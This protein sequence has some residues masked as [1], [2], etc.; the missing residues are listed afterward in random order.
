MSTNYVGYG[1]SVLTQ[2]NPLYRS[3]DEVTGSFEDVSGGTFEQDSLD[4][5]GVDDGEADVDTSDNDEQQTEGCIGELLHSRWAPFSHHGNY[6]AGQLENKQDT[7]KYEPAKPLGRKYSSGF[8]S[9]S[10]LSDEGDQFADYD[11]VY[12]STTSQFAAQLSKSLRE[13]LLSPKQSHEDDM[14]QK[15]KVSTAL[16]PTTSSVSKPGAGGARSLLVRTLTMPLKYAAQHRHSLTRVFS[17]SQPSTPELPRRNQLTR[18]YVK[19]DQFNQSLSNSPLN[20]D[21]HKFGRFLET[22]S[23][24]LKYPQFQRRTSLGRK[25]SSGKPPKPPTP[26]PKPMTRKTSSLSRQASLKN[27]FPGRVAKSPPPNVLDNWPA[28]PCNNPILEPCIT[29]A[30]NVA[31]NIQHASIWG[32]IENLPKGYISNIDENK[33]ITYKRKPSREDCKLQ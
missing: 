10:D 26:H 27:P 24:G 13:K 29:C 5:G 14:H 31:A 6:S 2:N 25:S 9:N 7:A 3:Y 22:S 30:R 20:V 17:R 1:A 12:D 21:S 19:P 4:G 23:Q 32:N 33:M 15:L 16:S 28:E 8:S 18:S 11:E